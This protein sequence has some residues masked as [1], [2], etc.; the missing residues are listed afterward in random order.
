LASF[1]GAVKELF[2]PQQDRLS[3]DDWFEEFELMDSPSL[4]PVEIGEQSRSQL[5]QGWEVG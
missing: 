5:R 1:I 3:D 4:P 2:G